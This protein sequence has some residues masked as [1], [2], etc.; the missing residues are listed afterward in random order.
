M[1]YIYL[2]SWGS[3]ITK[4]NKKLLEPSYIEDVCPE[5]K[6]LVVGGQRFRIVVAAS[7]DPSSLV[8]LLDIISTSL[9]HHHENQWR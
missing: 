3:I 9:F 5:P 2:S 8:V 6:R 7:R 1:N 4:T